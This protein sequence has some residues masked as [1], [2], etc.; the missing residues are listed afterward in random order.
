MKSCIHKLLHDRSG[1]AMLEFSLGAGLL[2]AAFTG[3][4]QFGYTFLQYNQLQNAT[5]RAAR[6]ASLAP[7]DSIT[8]T[9][10]VAFLSAVQNMVLYGDPAGGATPV[11]PRLTAANVQLTVTFTNNIPSA[12]T[13]S[14]TGYS[15]DAVFAVTNF[16]MKPK[17]TYAYQGIWSPV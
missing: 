14:I 3:T 2:V 15:V 16:N 8:A 1:N 13:V 6:Y 17:V 4:F 11:L 9:P 7:Y 10:S 12:M 5:A